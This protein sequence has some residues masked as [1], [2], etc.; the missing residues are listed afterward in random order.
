[1]ALAIR[2]AARVVFALARLKLRTALLIGVRVSRV[3]CVS[4]IIIARV[5]IIRV[6]SQCASSSVVCVFCYEC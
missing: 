4:D 2:R 3:L 6:C 1:M 5:V